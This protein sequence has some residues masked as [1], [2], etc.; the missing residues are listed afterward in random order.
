MKKHF[1][2]ITTNLLNNRKYIGDHS[3]NNLEDGYLGSGIDPKKDISKYGKKNFYRKIL[4]FFDS[5]QEAFNAQKKYIKIYNTHIYEGGYNRNWTGGQWA[6]NPSKK[7]KEKISKG[8][9]RSFKENPEI[10]KIIFN[11]YVSYS[12]ITY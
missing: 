8:V 4:E 1:T 5:K 2:Y 12:N 7:T 3:T 11:K 10:L 9:I 6:S